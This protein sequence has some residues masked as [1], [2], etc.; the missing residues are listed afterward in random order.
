MQ[1]LYVENARSGRSPPR[2]RSS[3][4]PAK[5]PNGHRQDSAGAEG[6]EQ[7]GW[8]GTFRRTFTND[9]LVAGSVRN[10]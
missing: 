2:C 3:S 7:A 8:R 1:L 9:M 5:L 10:T 4:R 6:F